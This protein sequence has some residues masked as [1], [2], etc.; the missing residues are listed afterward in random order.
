MEEHDIV[1]WVIKRIK[2]GLADELKGLNPEG[3]EKALKYA[4]E[5]L[6]QWSEEARKALEANKETPNDEDKPH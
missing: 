5:L 1:S 2:G 3:G 6:D 4:K